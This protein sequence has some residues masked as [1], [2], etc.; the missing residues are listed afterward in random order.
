MHDDPTYDARPCD[1]DRLATS[2]AREPASAV[3]GRDVDAGE[4]GVLVAVELRKAAPEDG[5]RASGDASP[6]DQQPPREVVPRERMRERLPRA[7]AR[8]ASFGGFQQE[9]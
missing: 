2:F 3:R 5:T 7:S 6:R 8:H 1:D 4:F 9:Q